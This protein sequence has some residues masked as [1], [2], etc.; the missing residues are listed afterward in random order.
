MGTIHLKEQFKQIK[1]W[2]T[3]NRLIRLVYIIERQGQRVVHGR[4]IQLD[5]TKQMILMYLDDEKSMESIKMNA[6]E[7][8]EPAGSLGDQTAG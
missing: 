6:I 7:T 5:E 8:M 1:K 3:E 4:I 2:I